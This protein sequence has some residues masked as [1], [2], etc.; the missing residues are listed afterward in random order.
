MT[1]GIR[2]TRPPFQGDGGRGPE[3]KSLCSE[4]QFNLGARICPP[5]LWLQVLCP[6]PRSETPCPRGDPESPDSRWEEGGSEGSSPSHFRSEL[7][8][9][10][11]ASPPFTAEASPQLHSGP[12]RCCRS[13]AWQS[14]D[15]RSSVS[16]LHPLVTSCNVTDEQT[17][18]GPA[19]GPATWATPHRGQLTSVRRHREPHE[20]CAKATRYSSEPLVLL[21]TFHLFLNWIIF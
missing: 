9:H 5:A 4:S 8:R 3:V 15:T 17:C 11:F 13:L 1:L 7:G 18:V 20:H 16:S 14:P 10:H 21:C 6:K 12:P 2:Y 19:L